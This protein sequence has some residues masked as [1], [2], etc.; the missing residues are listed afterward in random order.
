MREC[1]TKVPTSSTPEP[2]GR[3][4][5]F[6]GLSTVVA[7]DLAACSMPVKILEAKIPPEQYPD[8]NCDALNIERARLLL[9]ALRSARR[10][11]A[12]LF[13]A[14]PPTPRGRVCL[15][16]DLISTRRCSLQ[17]SMLSETPSSQR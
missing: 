3:F 11:G 5:A 4:M 10:P 8:L 7:L 1:R 6:A 15:P 2:R 16:R 17:K 12:S 13:W 9:E 14:M